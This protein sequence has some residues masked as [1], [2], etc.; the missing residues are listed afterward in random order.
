MKYAT[1]GAVERDPG[2]GYMAPNPI[3][4]AAPLP[5]ATPLPPGASVSVGTENTGGWNL[6]NF[7]ALVGIGA[8]LQ[9]KGVNLG[10][11]QGFDFGAAFRKIAAAAAV[12]SAGGAVGIAIA[13]LVAVIGTLGGVWERLQNPNWY[14][15]GPGVHQWA[16]Q[17][18]PSAF[19]SEAQANGT[20]TWANV[21][22]C[23]RHLLSWFMAKDGAVMTGQSG[24]HY[25]GVSDDVYV[26]AAGGRAF[27]RTF[28]ADAGVDYEGTIAARELAGDGRANQNVMMY[29]IQVNPRGAAPVV[30]EPGNPVPAGTGDI[31]GGAG[32]GVG[33]VA[34]LALVGFL[35][36]GG[37]RPRR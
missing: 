2:P 7:A 14:Q 26:V 36:L 18:A 9:M 27:L 11:V 6:D 28:Y 8:D 24:R 17:F 25:S 23:A 12:G 16:T 3:I 15:V 31:F 29:K 32:W 13:V 1:I 22:Q 37:S 33:T 5:T 20:N 30:L 19:I 34:A 10:P 35:F 4:V 21:E